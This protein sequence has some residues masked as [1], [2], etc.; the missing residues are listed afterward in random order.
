[1]KDAKILASTDVSETE[2]LLSDAKALTQYNIKP[3]DALHVASALS[4]NSDYFLTT[5]DKLLSAVK[6]SNLIAGLNP[7]EYIRKVLE[8]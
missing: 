4:G 8:K 1:M 5:D 3:K 6:R 2:E 7:T